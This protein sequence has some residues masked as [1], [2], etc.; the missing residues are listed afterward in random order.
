MHPQCLHQWA[1]SVSPNRAPFPPLKVWRL[2]SPTYASSGARNRLPV[3]LLIYL[4]AVWRIAAHKA[5]V[6]ASLL[7]V[8]LAAFEFHMPASKIAGAVASG[9]VY[10]AFRI[11]WVLLA[12]V[13]RLQPDGGIREIRSHQ[14]IDSGASRRTGAC[15]RC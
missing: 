1:P 12:A 10:G 15:K 9:V 7:C 2:S 8:A 6:Y 13:F 4:L 5:A 11:A 3:C 14:A